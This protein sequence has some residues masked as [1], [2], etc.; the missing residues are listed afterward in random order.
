MILAHSLYD[1]LYIL[2]AE[3]DVFYILFQL[4]FSICRWYLSAVD[5]KLSRSLSLER[6]RVCVAMHAG[7]SDVLGG[8]CESN[9]R[10]CNDAAL[11]I[12]ISGNYFPDRVSYVKNSW[13]LSEIF[14]AANWYWF[15]KYYSFDSSFFWYLAACPI[16][17]FSRISPLPLHLIIPFSYHFLLYHSIWFDSRSNFKSYNLPIRWN[18]I[19]Y[20]SL[21]LSLSVTWIDKK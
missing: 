17:E 18:K 1:W 5:K 10:K 3:K 20:I 12:S 16:V 9:V 15:N 2:T 21:S 7:I 19:V 6:L 11:N 4:C 13:N 8:Y 14:T